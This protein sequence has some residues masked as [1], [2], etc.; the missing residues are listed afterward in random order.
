MKLKKLL[1]VMPE[2]IVK[3]SKEIEITG[4]CS[5]S[6]ITS[7][8]CLF[9]AKKG[10]ITDGSK[11]ISEAIAGG[12]IAIVTDLY[13]PTYKDVTQ[14][15]TNQIEAVE[16]CLAAEYYGDPS[17]TLNMIGITGTNGKTTVAYLVKYIL[18]QTIGKTGLI[19]TI[20]YVIGEHRL[21][22]T[23]TTPDIT[24]NHKMLHEM[25][26]SGCNSAVMEVTS[27]ALKQER[28]KHIH[29]DIAVF[30]NLSQDHLDY[31][32]SMEE[33]CRA[34]NLLFRNIYNGV[35]VVNSDDQYFEKII[36]GCKSSVLTY[37]I[38]VQAN[39]MAKNIHYEHKTTFFDL[40]YKEK[41]YPCNIPLLGKHNVYN[42][43]AAIGVAIKMQIPIPKIIELI[44]TFPSISGRLESVDND[45][46]IQVFVDFA[47]TEEAL[48]NILRCL[49]EMTSARIITVFGCGGN[50]DKTKR[51][52]M[53]KAVEEL[54]DF[55]VVTSDNPRNE[56]PQKIIEDILVG[57]SPNAAY[58][59][60]VDRKLA[61]IHAIEMAVPGDVVL[62][63]GRGHESNQ[64]FS[65]KIVE[66]CDSKVAK[67]A[68][69]NI[70]SLKT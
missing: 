31:H 1:K 70:F 56:D 29:Y 21:P 64:I 67:E 48:K 60:E 10:Q 40:I 32:G 19:G 11:Y 55:A 69:D 53:A 15:I 4:I 28:V 20:E 22:A 3:G 37:G 26:L 51:P 17:K 9:I 2:L 24:Q 14:L 43:L 50:R 44:A 63:A 52:K 8:G 13:D 34:K 12:A 42:S 46:G 49:R 62:I 5:N 33:Y 41:S 61:I 65:H 25:L 39:L 38:D 47:H 35:C 45:L 6:Q 27:H 7:P 16:A 54:S 66:F 58:C 30:T 36:D 18:D 23:H 57:F 59:V 68:C